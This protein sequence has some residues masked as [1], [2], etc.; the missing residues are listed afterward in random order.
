MEVSLLNINDYRILQAIILNPDKSDQTLPHKK[1]MVG[2]TVLNGKTKMDIMKITSL[3][4]TKV[5]STIKK[6]LEL[7]YIAE[8]LMKA[9]AKTYYITQEG[10]NELKR[11][12]TPPQN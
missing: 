6:L 11:V 12:K 5:N 3:G 4:R 2:N 10:K 7:G 9:R 8:G 1:I